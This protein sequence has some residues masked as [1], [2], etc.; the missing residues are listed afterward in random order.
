MGIESKLAYRHWLR[1]S[2]EWETAKLMCRSWLAMTCQGCGL[3]SKH[4]HCHHI[5]YKDNWNKTKMWDLRLLCKQ[6]HDDIHEL[7]TPSLYKDRQVA[8]HAFIIAANILREEHGLEL[9]RI[10]SL[11]IPWAITS[12]FRDPFSLKP[13]EWLLANPLPI[14]EQP[15]P[16]RTSEKASF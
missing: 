4:N 9:L 12:W 10:R 3:I 2:F 14:A 16:H 8:E 15:S 6:C 11:K 1:S 13:I 5:R 7:T